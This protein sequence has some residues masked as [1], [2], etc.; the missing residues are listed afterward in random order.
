MSRTPSITAGP[1]TSPT[2][3]SSCLPPASTSTRLL[4]QDLSSPRGKI[5]R[6]NTDGTVPTDNPFYDGA[7]PHYDA[8]WALGLRNPYRAYYDAPTGRL[9]IGDVGGND[10]STAKEEVDLGCPRRQLRLAEL[11]RRL[12]GTVHQPAVLLRAQRR[13]AAVTGGFVYHGTQFP[14]GMQGNYFFG[15]YAQNWI[16]RMT[17]DANGNV[18]GVFN[19]EPADGTLD[20]PTGD[21]VYLTEGPDGALYYIDLGYSDISGTFGVSKVRRIRYQQANQAPIAVA[22]ATPTSGPLPLAVAFSSAGSNDP[23]G[24]PVTY[25]WDFGD[26]TTSAAANPTH[27]YSA[28]GNYTVRLTVSDGVN[29]TFAPPITVTAGS[30]PRRR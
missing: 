1:S 2:T 13:D 21:I 20:G 29:S 18:T 3:E 9:F 26:S 23:E 24:Q 12:H 14:A 19:F 8:I 16:R 22:G 6:F 5:L 7:G 15:D 17:F 28:A 30:R 10:A 27:T 25:A 11:R 4:S